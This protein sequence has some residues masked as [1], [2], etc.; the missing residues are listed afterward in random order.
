MTPGS[1][2]ERPET[3]SETIVA[4]PP[5]ASKPNEWCSGTCSEDGCNNGCAGYKGHTGAHKCLTH[6]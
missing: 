4:V 2:L 3:A 6:A 5:T 1:V